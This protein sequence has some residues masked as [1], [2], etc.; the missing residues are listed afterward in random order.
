LSCRDLLPAGRRAAVL[1][2]AAA[3]VVLGVSGCA[4]G[5][6]QPSAGS[7]AGSP[8]RAVPADDLTRRIAGVE[9]ARQCT[10]TTASFP[11]ESDITADLDTRLAAAGLTHAQW[12]GWHDALVDSPALVA[13]LTQA[14]AAGC[15]AG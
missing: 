7:D 8:A 6:G 9:F 15:P 3:A 12:K 4:A 11:S 13:Q 2:L 10:V 14:G 5:T 1:G